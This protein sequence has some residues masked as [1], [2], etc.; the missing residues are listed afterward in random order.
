[1]VQDSCCYPQRFQSALGISKLGPL[2]EMPC[3]NLRGSILWLHRV[4]FST[5]SISVVFTA[6]CFLENRSSRLRGSKP[7][8]PT[9]LGDWGSERAFVV[10]KARRGHWRWEEPAQ[11]Q[12]MCPNAASRHWR[13]VT[14]AQLKARHNPNHFYI[15]NSL[16]SLLQGTLSSELVNRM[17]YGRNFS[18]TK[19]CSQT[20]NCF[21]ILTL[22]ACLKHHSETC[23]VASKFGELLFQ[24][25]WAVHKRSFP[26]TR[27]LLLGWNYGAETGGTR[28]LAP[29][30]AL[31]T[32]DVFPLWASASQ[33][34]LPFLPH[35]IRNP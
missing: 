29:G 7:K 2:L 25:L 11:P 13:W 9:G 5:C 16:F 34:L 19:T 4:P 6:L 21:V 35:Y 28:D 18:Y 15:L 27:H 22:F 31:W 10:A 3:S 20:A 23:T 32:M 30:P 1:M 26:L 17:Q 33:T 8:P 14:P 12:K 24:I